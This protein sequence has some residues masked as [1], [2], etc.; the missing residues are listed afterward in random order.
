MGWKFRGDLLLDRHPSFFCKVDPFAGTQCLF[1]NGKEAPAHM[2]QI[3]RS[4]ALIY[5]LN[6]IGADPSEPTFLRKG[7]W[8]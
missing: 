5:A 6:P 2:P 3:K 4:L 7:G 8:E 1:L